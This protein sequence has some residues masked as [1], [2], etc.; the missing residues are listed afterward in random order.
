M[1]FGERKLLINFREIDPYYRDDTGAH[2]YALTRG[3]RAVGRT[4]A[5]ALL[6]A[7]R[8]IRGEVKFIDGSSIGEHRVVE[9]TA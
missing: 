6:M 5:A 3:G 2:I 4:N 8:M 7:E 9:R 1:L